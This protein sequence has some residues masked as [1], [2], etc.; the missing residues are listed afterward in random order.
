MKKVIVETMLKC[1]QILSVEDNQVD[2]MVKNF[3]DTNIHS[4]LLADA[5][6]DEFDLDSVTV[7]DKKVFVTEGEKD[8]LTQVCLLINS[9]DDIRANNDL[10]VIEK[11][12]L[13]AKNNLDI[14]SI[15]ACL[16]KELAELRGR[17]NG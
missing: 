11:T 13:I 14:M 2:F 1:T 15:V 9:S 16:E 4:G 5:I 17:N 8:A 3:R 6:K 7:E 12:G 10:T